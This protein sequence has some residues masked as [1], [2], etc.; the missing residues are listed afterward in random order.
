MHSNHGGF[1]KTFAEAYLRADMEN[2]EIL[3]E[4]WE[5]LIVKYELAEEYKKS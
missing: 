4:A 5:R 3:K 1:L 2:K